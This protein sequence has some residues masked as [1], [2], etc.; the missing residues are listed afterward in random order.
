[1][2]WTAI[3]IFIICYAAGAWYWEYLMYSAWRDLS[4]DL[5]K[6]HGQRAAYSRE[7]HE[8]RRALQQL[9]ATIKSTSNHVDSK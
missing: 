5:D 2:V 8:I 7:M 4:R 6:M 1:M 3:C 9:E